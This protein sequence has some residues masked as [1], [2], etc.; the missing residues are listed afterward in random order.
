M[1]VRKL[2][3]LLAAAGMAA[4]PLASAQAAPGRIGAPVV[5]ANYQDDDSE[6]GGSTAVILGVVLLVLIG[7][8]AVSGDGEPNS[9]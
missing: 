7:I 5:N 3:L 6:G 4:A 8:V 2:S 1:L 9:P